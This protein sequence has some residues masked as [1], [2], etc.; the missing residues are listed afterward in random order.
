ME[1]SN[2]ITS[3]T[4]HP[5]TGYRGEWVRDG[6]WDREGK[7]GTSVEEV[8]VEGKTEMY[9]ETVNEE[10]DQMK[11]LDTSASG[12]YIDPWQVNRVDGEPGEQPDE[13]PGGPTSGNDASTETTASGSSVS[14]HYVH[15]RETEGRG[16]WWSR[17]SRRGEQRDSQLGDYVDMAQKSSPQ[18]KTRNKYLTLLG[19]GSNSRRK[20]TGHGSSAPQQDTQAQRD[21]AQ[22]LENPNYD[23]LADTY[24]HQ[25]LEKSGSSILNLC[26]RDA[27][28]PS[29]GL[30]TS[31]VKPR[32]KYVNLDVDDL[33]APKAASSLQSKAPTIPSKKKKGSKMHGKHQSVGMSGGVAQQPVSSSIGMSGGVAQQPVSSSVGMSGG[34]AQQPVSSSVGMSGGVAQQPV[35]SSIGMSGGVVLQPASVGG[36]KAGQNVTK[37]QYINLD[38]DHLPAPKAASSSQSKA[39]TIPTKKKKGSKMPGKHQSVDM[40]GGMAQQPV[41]SSVGMS[42]GV[43]LQPVS[44]GGTKAG[45]NV[46]KQQY[47]N[48]DV[49]NLP[50]PKPAGHLVHKDRDF[51]T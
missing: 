1:I 14:Y 20:K 25:D 49:D 10:P 7:K 19:Y 24:I 46:T 8:M 27:E 22:A 31:A 36:T 9:L 44:V 42:G 39:Q 41:S 2:P 40:S 30:E 23:T 35:S 37:Q 11:R 29:P 12:T 5:R 21:C 28:V 15:H 48:L 17:G 32:S 50:A 47:I 51:K 45:Q 26:P 16:K 43:A 13:Q 4:N 18:H 38:V 33:P 3:L 6:G 34:V